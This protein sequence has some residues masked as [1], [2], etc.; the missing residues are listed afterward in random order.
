MPLVVIAS[1]DARCC[2]RRT[3][4]RRPARA[5]SARPIARIGA[6]YRIDPV[7]DRRRL[8][9]AAADA[10]S[11][12][13]RADAGSSTWTPESFAS[14]PVGGA[15]L[16]GTDDGTGSALTLFDLGAGCRRDRRGHR[17]T[18][19]A[20]RSSARI[21]GPS[22]APRGPA[23][24]GGPRRVATAAGRRCAGAHA[25]HPWWQTTRSARRGG[26]SCHGAPT[27]GRWSSSR[28]ARSPVDSR[29]WTRRV[30]HIG[31]SRIRRSAASSG[32]SEERS[33]GAWRV[34]WAAVSAALDRR[35]HGPR[36]GARARSRSS[37]DRA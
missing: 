12:P 37:R 31:S 35:R 33:G 34:P 10:R 25:S 7:L 8:E 23:H 27:V 28:A 30:P 16:V 18:S 1:T 17:G 13:A 9:R 11:W 20:T 32:S 5:R 19:S 36:D 22:R 2:V 29:S 26:R 15:V 14:G 6:W 24:P 3:G 21:G 4:I